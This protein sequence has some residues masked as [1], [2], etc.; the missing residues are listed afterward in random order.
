MQLLRQVDVKVTVLVLDNIRVWRV[1]RVDKLVFASSHLTHLATS[2]LL[3]IKLNTM[4]YM[5]TEIRSAREAMTIFKILGIKEVTTMRQIANG[6]QVF[7]LPVRQMWGPSN[8]PPLRFATYTTGYVRNVTEG[9]AS[10]YQINK[11]KKRPAGTDGYH[12]ETVE[13][14]LIPNWEDRLIYLAKFIIK[15]YYK[16]PTYLISDYTM[17]TI[18]S[19]YKQ[20]N[21]LR[22]GLHKLPWGDDEVQV[23]ING[24]RYNLS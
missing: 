18:K 4:E 2:F 20:A 13:R 12:F 17:D 22:N 10:S 23:I 16:K 3:T 7:E 11:T 14:I 21:E 15:N 9:L 1:R 19:Q 24:H 8:M 5:S 6:T